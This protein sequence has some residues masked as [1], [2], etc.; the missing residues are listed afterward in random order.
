MVRALAGLPVGWQAKACPTKNLASFEG[1]YLLVDAGAG[2]GLLSDLVSDL[3]S[4]LLSDL[5]PVLISLL[6]SPWE[7]DFVSDFPFEPAG[8]FLPLR[9]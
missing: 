4:D 8:G 2:A 5:A 3:V 1:G 7:S 6:D 9:P